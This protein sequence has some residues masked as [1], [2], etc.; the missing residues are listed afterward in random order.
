VET[1]HVRLAEIAWQSAL[2]T[3]PTIF[4]RKEGW[5]LQQEIKIVTIIA[6]TEA[7]AGVCVK[8]I[9]LERNIPSK[10]L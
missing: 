2:E 10:Q 1:W 7:V 9:I 8:G 6:P 4:I 3:K 5:N